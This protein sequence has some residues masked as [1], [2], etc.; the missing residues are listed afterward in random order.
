LEDGTAVQD[1]GLGS[2]PKGYL[3]YD[4]SG[5]MAVQ[6]MRADRP[7]AIDC[8]TSNSAASDNSPQIL[9]GYEV[10]FGTALYWLLQAL[11]ARLILA[12]LRRYNFQ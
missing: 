5:H 8:G 12:D 4:S 2:A 9:S 7:L 3:M 1:H 11:R 6:L 10:Y